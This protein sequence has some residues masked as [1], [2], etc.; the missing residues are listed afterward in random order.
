MPC[1]AV[2]FVETGTFFGDTSAFAKLFSSKVVT[3]EPSTELYGAAVKRFAS[4]NP[5]VEVIN[6]PSEIALPEVV[7][8]LD[9]DVTFWLDGHY[10]GGIT[11]EGEQHSPLLDELECVGPHLPRLGAVTVLVDDIH[12]CGTNP[13]CPPIATVLKWADIHQLSWQI[14]HDI[15]IL[16]KP[17]A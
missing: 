16:R 9:G 3:I 8:R 14:E 15:L 6:A 10:S 5:M 2:T 17:A 7:K 11:F 1:G 13:G 12:A 4:S